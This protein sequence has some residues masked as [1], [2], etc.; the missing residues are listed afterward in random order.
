M[1]LRQ[2]SS[3]IS[4]WPLWV[5]IG[6]PLLLIVIN[7]SP[8]APNFVFVMIGLPALLLAW[9]ALGIF[10]LVITILRLRKRAWR[11][12]LISA[13]LPIVV[14]GVSINLLGFIHFCNNTGDIVHFLVRRPSYL[15]AIEA[16]PPNGRS[17]LLVFNRGGM[18]WSSRGFVYDESDEV[19]RDPSLQSPGW[20]DEA[21]NSELGCG[22]GAQSIPGHFAFTQH[23]YLASFA[24]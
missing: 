20:K 2:E 1:S 8:L 22:Y 12:A 3:R 17:R 10:A 6:L 11:S 13:V 18:S 23:W 4:F 19:L 15:K 5:A 16:T 24:C 14:I 7:S 9:A 21:Q